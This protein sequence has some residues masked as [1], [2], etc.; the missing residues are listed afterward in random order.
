MLSVLLDITSFLR[1]EEGDLEGEGKRKEKG[2]EKEKK[3]KGRVV[4]SSP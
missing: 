2:K 1:K 3:G 4:S